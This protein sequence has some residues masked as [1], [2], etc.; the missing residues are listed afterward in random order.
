MKKN[1][2]KLGVLIFSICLLIFACRK[3]LDSLT[4]D[5][6][7]AEPA[8]LSSAQ[9]WQLN[10]LEKFPSKLKKTTLKPRW[11]MAWTMKTSDGKEIM[12]VPTKQ[13]PLDNNHSA[14]RFYIFDLKGTSVEGGKI[15]EI[16]SD[17]YD[18]TEHLSELLPNLS[19]GDIIYYNINYRRA[20]SGVYENGIKTDKSVGIAK[21]SNIVLQPDFQQMTSGRPLKSLTSTYYRGIEVKSECTYKVTYDS[22]GQIIDFRENEC[23]AP[24][25]SGSGSG[26]LSG[27]QP[28]TLL[29]GE[30]PTVVIYGVR[31]GLRNINMALLMQQY[32]CLGRVITQMMDK[33]NFFKAMSDPFHDIPFLDAKKQ[34]TLNITTTSS[35]VFPA[36]GITGEAKLGNMNYDP[37]TNVADLKLSEQMLANSSRL[38]IYATIIHEA[39]HGHIRQGVD[40]SQ[41]GLDTAPVYGD[42]HTWTQMYGVP[43]GFVDHLA[44][45]TFYINATASLL[46]ELDGYQ[47]D[48]NPANWPAQEKKYYMA[49]LYGT[50]REGDGPIQ[51]YILNTVYAQVMTMHGITETEIAEFNS[52]NVRVPSQNASAKLP[53]SGPGCP[54]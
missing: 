41:S 51:Q 2:L 50:N 7:S 54:F 8:A 40:M 22:H 12:V 15:V 46:K 24:V 18:V 31:P 9:S 16:L 11:N 39:L 37:D 13:R 17:K 49:A 28:G 36:P 26:S 43:A 10:A 42:M 3:Q 35:F 5:F 14:R 45:M 30:L 44:M 23:P 52:A 1:R 47:P 20:G 6:P 27:D 48:Q 25:E 53:L 21:G 19:K 38:M 33:S 4:G 34:P 32:P 29:G